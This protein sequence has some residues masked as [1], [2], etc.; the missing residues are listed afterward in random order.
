MN[1]SQNHIKVL[2][3]KLNKKVYRTPTLS[4]KPGMKKRELFVYG[5]VKRSYIDQY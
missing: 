4:L 1:N 2:E 5:K 3:E